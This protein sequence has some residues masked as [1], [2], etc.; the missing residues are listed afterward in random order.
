LKKA[1]T[2]IE[3]MVAVMIVFVAVNAVMN[4][5]GNNKKLIEIFIKNK[6]FVLKSSVAFIEDKDMK[7]N[8][9]RLLEFNIKDDKIL[10]ILKKDEIKLDK[11]EDIREEY[12][13]S[14]IN[15][16]KV[17]EKLKAYDKTHSAIIYSIGIQ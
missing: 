4:I 9:E 12:N 6:E 5:I 8:Y 16:T 7:N 14:N 11:T 3:V 13:F 10:H 1:F 15:F 17:I 2:L